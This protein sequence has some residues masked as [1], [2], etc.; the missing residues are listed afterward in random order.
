MKTSTFRTIIG[1]TPVL[2][3]APHAHAHRRP[4]LSGAYKYGEP[5]T[6]VIVEQLCEMSNGFGIM[7]ISETDYDYN[8]HT[9]K[10]NPYKKR[11]KE[12]VKSE[13]IKYFL[14]IH[15]LKDGCLYDIAIYYPTKFTKSMRLA[16]SL[17]EGIDKGVLKGIN[18][19]IFRH[20]N[21]YQ[22]SLGEFVASEL[23]VPSVQIEI[24]RY[25]RESENLRNALI[26]NISKCV[27]KEII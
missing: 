15:G 1:K 23:R 8:Y 27:Q 17:K 2:F 7:Q 24:A 12:F 21:N 19:M 22:E 13:K 3:S 20:P 18:I 25:I 5:F 26:E 11:V 6:D 16:R 4:Q 9:E 14:D 10:D